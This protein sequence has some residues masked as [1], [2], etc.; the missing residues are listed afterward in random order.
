MRHAVHLALAAVSLAAVPTFSPAEEA[1]TNRTQIADRYKWKLDELYP[2]D[3]AWTRAREAFPAK[4]DAFALRR[5]HLGE[6]AKAVVDALTQ[7]SALRMEVERLRVYGQSRNDEDTRDA[8]SRAMRAESE[9][10]AVKLD[11]AAAWVRPELLALPAARLKALAVEPRLKDWRFY[12]QDVLR[13]KPHTLPAGEEQL[14]SKAGELMNAPSTTF[15]ILTNADLPYPTVQL[16]TGEKVR[17][18]DAG[19]TQCRVRGRPRRPR[20]VFQAFFGALQGLRA[21]H[22][23]DAQRRRQGARLRQGG[24]PVRLRLEAALFRDDIP[25][26]RVQAAHRGRERQPAHAPPLPR[27][28][29]SA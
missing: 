28:C 3:D 19:Y 14:V 21:H 9:S 6:G 1:A 13:W 25:V 23:H 24:P 16:S 15:N 8:R 22:R 5:G 20:K 17:L 11:A 7:L 27:S 10:L 4:V 2:S 18:D 29:A 26:A 12:L